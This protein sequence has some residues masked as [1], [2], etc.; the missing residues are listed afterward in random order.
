MV[1]K[2]KGVKLPKRVAG[3]KLSKRSRKHASSVIG[4]LRTPEAKALMGSALAALAGAISHR[5]ETA[6][7][8]RQG[9]K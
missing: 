7:P 9:H 3:F 5:K 1:K 4:L 8:V 2:S 6:K